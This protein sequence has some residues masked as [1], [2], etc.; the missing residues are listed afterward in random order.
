MGLETALLQ[1]ACNYAN[2]KEAELTR[3]ADNWTAQVIELS[4]QLETVTRERD[5]ALLKLDRIRRF[6]G[7][8]Q[9]NQ[10]E[11]PKADKAHPDKGEPVNRRPVR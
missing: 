8:E 2:E 6:F 7:E 9:C 11:R 1:A 3:Y 10:A 5:E 4:Q